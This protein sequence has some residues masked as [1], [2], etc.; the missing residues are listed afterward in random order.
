MNPL[1]AAD[2]SQALA[3]R[4]TSLR[5]RWHAVDGKCMSG[6]MVAHMMASTWSGETPA[7]PSALTLA[8]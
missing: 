7:D 5:C 6:V 3:F 2:T 1:H 4:A 8:S